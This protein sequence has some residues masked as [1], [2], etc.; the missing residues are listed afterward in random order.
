M[1]LVELNEGLKE[2]WVGFG[3]AEVTTEEGRVLFEMG[4]A[5]SSDHIKQFF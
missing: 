1:D 4:Q 5:A 3:V 2:L